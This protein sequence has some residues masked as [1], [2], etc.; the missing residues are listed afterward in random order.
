MVVPD[1]MVLF[2][3]ITGAHGIKGEVKLKSFAGEPAAIAGYGP[4]ATSRGAPIEIVALVRQRDGFVAKLKG[5]AD[6]NRA[7]ALKGSELF[8]PRSR[9]PQAEAGEVYVHDLIGLAVRGKD[10]GILGKIVAVPNYGAG[11]LLEVKVEGRKETLL[12]PFAD[13]FV[14]EIDA[15]RGVVVDL[16]DGY[17]D[18]NA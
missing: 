4:L 11:D 7:E 10:G 1:D 9:L 15:V 14:P 3:V 6:R 5:V 2:G 16:P 8:V 13:A 18:E 12:V 17:M